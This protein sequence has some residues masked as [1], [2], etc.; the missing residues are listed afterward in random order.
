MAIVDAIGVEIHL[1]MQYIPHV[2]KILSP[3]FI[4]LISFLAPKAEASPLKVLQLNFNS[5]V[6]LDDGDYTI[7][8][9]RFNALVN[10]AKQNSP[11]IIFL[12]E[13]WNY[14][15]GKN[16]AQA[17]AEA[18]GYDFTY[19]INMG[20]P[21]LFYDG[22]AV[23]AKRELHL[24]EER[25]VKLPHSA[26]E[27]GDGKKWIIEFGSVSYAVAAKL[28]EANGR[29][30]YVYA[31]HLLGGND[32][33]RGDQSMAIVQDA[34]KWISTSG[35]DWNDSDVIIGG[36]FNS[37]PA[38]SGPSGIVDSG[39]VDSF[40]AIHPGDT[41]CT[42]CEVPS[43]PWFN[44]FTL[45]AGQ[46]P[47]QASFSANLRDDYIF[48][49]GLRP[50]ESTII[51]TA[52]IGGIWM[53]DHYGV[54]SKFDND[55]S[56]QTSMASHDAPEA[57]IPPTQIIAV[58]DEQFQCT[59]DSN[60]DVNLPG[61]EVSG[62]RGITL[63]NLSKFYIRFKM[64]GPG[65]IFATRHVGLNPGESANFSFASIG[66]YGFEIENDVVDEDSEDDVVLHGIINV[67]N[68]G[69]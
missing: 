58:T 7:R 32:M 24:S 11:D 40:A 26:F 20:F 22:D 57:A 63:R 36:D 38:D 6:L 25:D 43:E 3:L 13:S 52:P 49:H 45:V 66:Q 47:S 59:D 1:K 68:T 14:R 60:C 33:D 35:G 39:F 50:Y 69:Y 34:K 16:I 67:S 27:F 64:K 2:T 55:F 5:E 23:L 37:N 15:D 9:L 51:F 18:L 42:D 44:P 56:L 54:W 31:T 46:V 4:L 53:S 12:E 41:S 8:D 29:T 21:G 28:T 61:L 48:A 19:R 65:K 62:A 30:L 17:L 10:W